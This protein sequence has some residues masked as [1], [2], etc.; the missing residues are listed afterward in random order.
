MSEITE[1]QKC[2][3]AILD[4]LAKYNYRLQTDGSHV[5]ISEDISVGYFLIVVFSWLKDNFM[6]HSHIHL[7]VCGMCQPDVYNIDPTCNLGRKL[8]LMRKTFLM[9][10]LGKKDYFKRLHML[11]GHPYRS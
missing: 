3:W 10:A 7:N 8:K 4:F 11:H 2:T 9:A 6:P 5:W 1:E